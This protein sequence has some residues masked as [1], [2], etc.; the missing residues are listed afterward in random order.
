MFSRCAEIVAMQKVRHSA[1]SD[2]RFSIIDSVLFTTTILFLQVIIPRMVTDYYG[3]MIFR[4]RGYVFFHYM[5]NTNNVRKKGGASPVPSPS[6]ML[7]GSIVGNIVCE[8]YRTHL[9]VFLA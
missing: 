7:D 1:M 3:V 5:G 8:G 9:K 4:T 6:V 2:S